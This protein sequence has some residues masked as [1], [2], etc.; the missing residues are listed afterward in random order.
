MR[1]M[2]GNE[3]TNTELHYI[4]RILS[5]EMRNELIYE[6]TLQSYSRLLFVIGKIN[7]RAIIARKL[8]D[9]ISK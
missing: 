5:Q 1:T 6:Q 7:Q 4:A 8:R 2:S 9:L 3:E